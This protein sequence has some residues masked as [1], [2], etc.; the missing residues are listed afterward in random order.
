MMNNLMPEGGLT[1]KSFSAIADL[2]YRE[3]GL[4][5][6]AEK[7]SMI[8]SRLRHRLKAS[9]FDSFESYAEFVSSEEG[10]AERLQMISALTTNVSHFFREKHQAYLCAG[11][12]G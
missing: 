8:Q 6:F 11:L 10:K 1:A 12:G 2:A 5:L 9:G 7:A 3:S 4:Q